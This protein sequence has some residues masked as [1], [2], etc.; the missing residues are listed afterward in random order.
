MIREVD[1]EESQV[2]ELP[3]GDIRFEDTTN[4]ESQSRSSGN[5][6][7]HIEDLAYSIQSEGQKVPVTV[8][9]TFSPSGEQYIAINGNHRLGAIKKINE[10]T[11][12]PV[13]A[14]I[15]TFNS[16]QERLEYQIKQNEHL[17]SLRN[18]YND[19][20]N[21]LINLVK[22]ENACGD[23]GRFETDGERLECIKDYA[24]RIFGN[25]KDIS[26]LAKEAFNTTAANTRKIHNYTKKEAIEY[27]NTHRVLDHGKISK[28]GDF[29][30]GI[31]VYFEGKKLDLIKAHGQAIKFLKK[32]GD[33]VK[34]LVC[35]AWMDD[36]IGKEPDHVL[37]FREG[38]REEIEG[39][40]DFLG[41]EIFTKI[42]FLPQIKKNGSG[43]N[44][45]GSN[46]IIIDVSKERK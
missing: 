33:T 38:I 22:R 12:L 18:T 35:V 40:N 25:N 1:V 7:E 9:R 2:V 8:E 26:R 28:S 19:R 13:R 20:K 30:S 15:A 43:P 41:R 39:F 3:I 34:E 11:Q 17:P 29:D 16:N 24:K 5:R 6:S 4:R 36:C 21:A 46:F 44:D 45:N 37:K 10:E 32:H 27:F 42:F 31:G 23:L 14:V